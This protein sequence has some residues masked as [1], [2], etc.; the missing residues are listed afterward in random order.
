[1][2]K[3]QINESVGYKFKLV[4]TMNNIRQVG[5]AHLLGTSQGRIY[6]VESGQLDMP[7]EWIIKLVDLLNV[8]PMYLLSLSK[9]VYLSDIKKLSEQEEN[10]IPLKYSPKINEVNKLIAELTD[11]KKV[12][13]AEP[14]LEEA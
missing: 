9:T 7:P 13:K 10:E 14:E 12:N 3:N 11:K 6:G 1:M 2:A 5:M 8:N 4:R